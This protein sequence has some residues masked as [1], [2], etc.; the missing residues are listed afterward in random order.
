[1]LRV[2][3]AVTKNTETIAA[4]RLTVGKLDALLKKAEAEFA[5]YRTESATGITLSQAQ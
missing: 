5:K 3:A 1:M 4:A 2:D